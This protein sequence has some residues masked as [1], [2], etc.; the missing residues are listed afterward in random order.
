MEAW[1]GGCEL[2]GAAGDVWCGD[3]GAAWRDN[4]LDNRGIKGFAP[5]AIGGERFNGY[6]KRFAL[7]AK[8]GI[9]IGLDG[10]AMVV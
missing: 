4:G 9:G 5:V 7:V 10:F 1:D 2:Y 8:G 3:G 6:E